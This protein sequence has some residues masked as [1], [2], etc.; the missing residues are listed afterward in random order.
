MGLRPMFRP[1]LAALYPCSHSIF[2][3]SQQ[4]F[5]T[6]P[7]AS[8]SGAPLD[9][10]GNAVGEGDYH[11][12]ENYGKRVLPAFQKSKLSMFSFVNTTGSPRIT[13]SP[14]TLSSPSFPA[15]NVSAPLLRSPLLRATPACTAR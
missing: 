14:T 7:P 3:F 13:L 4:E 10:V 8:F 15:R 9:E 1:T 11:Q 6:A 5:T 2:S 12:I